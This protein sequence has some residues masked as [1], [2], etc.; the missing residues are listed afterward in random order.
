MTLFMPAKC[1][2]RCSELFVILSSL[3]TSMLRYLTQLD[4]LM[5]GLRHLYSSHLLPTTYT[6]VNFRK[7]ICVNYTLTA[8]QAWKESSSTVPKLS[9]FLRQ[10]NEESGLIFLWPSFNIC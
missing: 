9:I 5:L 7:S 1:L 2:L 10:S 4:A 6:T 8:N 3:T